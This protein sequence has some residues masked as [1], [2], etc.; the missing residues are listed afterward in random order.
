VKIYWPLKAE[1]IDEEVQDQRQTLFPMRTI[2]AVLL[3]LCLTGTARSDGIDAAT[4][5]AMIEDAHGITDLLG[6]QI[7]TIEDF[8]RNGSGYMLRD[9][10]G[11]LYHLPYG[12]ADG[13]SAAI[14]LQV[15]LG[16]SEAFQANVGGDLGELPEL[17]ERATW[18]EWNNLTTDGAYDPAKVNRFLDVFIPSTLETYDERNRD[19]LAQEIAALQQELRDIRT[20]I[21]DAEFELAALEAAEPEPADGEILDEPADWRTIMAERGAEFPAGVTLINPEPGMD[22]ACPRAPSEAPIWILV[23]DADVCS[24]PWKDRGSRGE[25]DGVNGEWCVWRPVNMYWVSG[26]GCCMPE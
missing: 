23:A 11:S 1:W 22:K 13:L 12:E 8:R 15:L 5:A 14:G 16:H 4:L 3:G 21:E 17:T 7:G 19:R 25:H 26:W 6:E 10:A 24:D 18:G 9:A 20:L 2:T